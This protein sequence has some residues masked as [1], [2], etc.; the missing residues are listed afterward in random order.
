MSDAQRNL[1]TFADLIALFNVLDV[2]TALS[3]HY[4][5]D[6]SYRYGSFPPV[7]GKHA[8]RQATYSSHL[9][10]VKGM[11]FEVLE[12][13]AQGD[14]VIAELELR[15]ELTDG[16]TLT[17]LCTDVVRFAPDGKVRD[18]RVYIDPSPLFARAKPRA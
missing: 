10:F 6:A 5:D 11:A 16:T 9:D 15:H 14:T 7:V 13:W 8:I 1:A 18:F 3:R 4:A 17:L 12:T 2:E